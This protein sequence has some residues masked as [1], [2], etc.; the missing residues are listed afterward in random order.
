MKRSIAFLVLVV[1]GVFSVGCA[2]TGGA[3]V[4]MANASFH[5]SA[6]GYDGFKFESSLDTNP[7]TSELT[8][9][10]VT[11][12]SSVGLNNHPSGKWFSS[13]FDVGPLVD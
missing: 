5:S 2:S 6:H 3:S 4:G 9:G 12:G 13:N 8:L 10:F 1:I 11:V 7:A